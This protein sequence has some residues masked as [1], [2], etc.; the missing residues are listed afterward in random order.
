[1]HA[2][3]SSWF[4]SEA[5]QEIVHAVDG[6][7]GKQKTPAAKILS[8]P[9]HRRE[10]R[11][12]IDA[13][14]IMMRVPIQ[15]KFAMMIFKNARRLA[16]V[17]S[18]MLCIGCAANLPPY[19]DNDTPGPVEI[20]VSRPN[21]TWQVAGAVFKLELDENG[22]LVRRR[23]QSRSLGGSYKHVF[24]VHPGDVIAIAM[25]SD[26]DVSTK[27]PCRAAYFFKVDS[28]IKRYEMGSTGSCWD[29]GFAY[30][31]ATGSGHSAKVETKSF[32]YP[33]SSSIADPA[34]ASCVRPPQG[35]A[36]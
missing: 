23:M 14:S 8:R 15:E 4:A 22:C 3:F 33:M 32:S 7:N 12:T 24:Y 1:M 28:G 2:C 36:E 35:F 11:L 18:G 29:K 9:H 10:G 19:V 6:T 21:H 25:A 16:A 34:P 17:S 27:R 20:I 26:Y 31:E 13:S 30:A 5:S